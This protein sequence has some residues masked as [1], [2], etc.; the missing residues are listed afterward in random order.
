MVG[1]GFPDVTRRELNVRGR[2]IFVLTLHVRKT[3]S[4]IEGLKVK[5]TYLARRNC[6]GKYYRDVCRACRGFPD[7]IDQE[8]KVRERPILILM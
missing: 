2:P 4:S 8:L 3:E 1:W 5:Q 7:V 6:G